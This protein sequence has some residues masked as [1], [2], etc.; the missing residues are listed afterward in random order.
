MGGWWEQEYFSHLSDVN[1]Y[2]LSH[3][4]TVEELV[5]GEL[6]TGVFIE[7]LE[8]LPVPL[9]VQLEAS[10]PQALAELLETESLRPI[11]VHTAEHSKRGVR[12]GE[13]LIIVAR[14]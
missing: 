12:L 3:P 6:P 1:L 7:G 14:Q 4:H 13:Y 11:V 8:H 10:I 9:I 5:N 2:S